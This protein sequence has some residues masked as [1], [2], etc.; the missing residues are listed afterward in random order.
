MHSTDEEVLS[1]AAKECLLYSCPEM[2]SIGS[3]S[4][5]D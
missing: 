3:A 2:V 1:V 4:G 5:D